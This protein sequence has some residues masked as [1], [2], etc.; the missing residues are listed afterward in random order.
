MSYGG[1][2]QLLSC[3]EGVTELRAHYRVDVEPGV[4]GGEEGGFN[5]HWREVAVSG[6]GVDV[7]RHGELRG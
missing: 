6:Y 4:G 3:S 2:G 5:L 1:A 7:A